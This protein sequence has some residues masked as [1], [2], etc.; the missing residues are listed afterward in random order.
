M[1]SAATR[2]S[3]ISERTVLTRSPDTGTV[4]VSDGAV[5]V[6]EPAGRAHALNHT[7][8]LVWDL[9]DGESALGDI[10]D[11]LS[12]VFGAPRK[13]VSS[14]VIGVARDLAMLGLLD[15]VAR[16]ITSLPVDIEFVRPD[17]CDDPA[18]VPAQ[19]A[20]PLDDRYL[21]VPPNG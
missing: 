11:D 8:G 10:V 1:A 2:P 17:D 21:G 3:E 20:P 15:G 16:A 19:P 14:D 6:D 13:V 7:A 4:K 9:L 5:V 12:G 18:A